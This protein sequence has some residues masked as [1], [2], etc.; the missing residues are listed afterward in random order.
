VQA[1]RGI[2]LHLKAH[3]GGA[4]ELQENVIFGCS[5]RYIDTNLIEL[6]LQLP[7]GS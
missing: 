2:V 7:S 5:Y 6:L 3:V 4:G 1:K